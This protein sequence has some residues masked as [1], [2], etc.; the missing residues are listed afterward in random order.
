MSKALDIGIE[1]LKK[2]GEIKWPKKG[3]KRASKV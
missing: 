2:R 1:E 3:Q